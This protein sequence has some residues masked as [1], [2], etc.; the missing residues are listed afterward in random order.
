M[1]RVELLKKLKIFD[2]LG[3]TYFK[4]NKLFFK[5]SKSSK[6]LYDEKS[7]NIIHVIKETKNYDS[8]PKIIWMFW[9][10]DN[11]PLEIQ[12]FVDKIK[13]ENPTYD[14]KILNFS[15]LN[16]YVSDLIFDDNVDIPIAN[17]TDLIRLALLYKF[18]GV[19]LDITTILFQPI[20]EF[21]N[22]ENINNY[23]LIA[24]YY[25]KTTTDL[26]R[27]MIESWFLAAPPRS[28]FIYEWLEALYPLL[29][30]GS[31]D[32]YNKV[33]ARADYDLIVQKITRPEYLLVY[34]AQQIVMLNS[35]NK[36]NFYLRKCDSSAFYIQEYFNWNP[37]EI[38]KYLAFKDLN[39]V[40]P[41][42]I[43][44]LTSGDRLFMNI[45][46]KYDL[47]VTNSILGALLK[48]RN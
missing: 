35:D 48:Y 33:K 43:I 21:L 39:N 4:F 24:F 25:E 42:P 12:T 3:F 9:N 20:D 16:Y 19:W 38:H 30:L 23:D 18:G 6:L 13:T 40:V 11:L 1:K 31:K 26:N 8:I 47:I 29:H 27:P 44:K 10:D 34:L 5:Y 45:L 14:V 41:S 32:Y 2:L 17:K 28:Q 7:Q 22:I 15:N 46:F 37:F 36:F